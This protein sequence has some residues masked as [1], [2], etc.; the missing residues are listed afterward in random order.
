MKMILHKYKSFPSRWIGRNRAFTLIELL[1]VLTIIVLLASLLL[2]VLAAAKLQARQTQ[3]L[4]NLKQLALAHTSYMADYDKDFPYLNSTPF[5]YGWA[6]M[7]I[8]YATN[9]V[10]IEICPCAPERTSPLAGTAPGTA[11]EAAVVQNQQQ[12]GD[13]NGVLQLSYAF[14]G[15]FYTGDLGYDIASGYVEQH[16]PSASAVQFPSRTPVFADAM[17]PATWPMSTNLPATNLYA[18]DTSLSDAM[19]V[20]MM[21]LTLARHGSRPASAAPRNFDITNTLPGS[22]NLAFF[23]GHVEN[24]RL[25][26]LWNYYWCYG[27]QV[28]GTRPN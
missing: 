12:E 11:D 9:S 25:E 4:S 27:Y 15:W 18:G 21:R 1:V 6:G 10:S 20:M 23:D 7:L 2:P 16:F 19:A 13:G 14:N 24:S 3:C 26:N 28:P 8:P 17:W 5:Y 22:I